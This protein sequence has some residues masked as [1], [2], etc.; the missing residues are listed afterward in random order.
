MS[1][2]ELPDLPPTI[3]LL[4]VVAWRYDCLERAGWPRELATALAERADVDLHLAV[5]L[6]RSGATIDQ[7]LEIVG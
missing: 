5:D 3:R 4:D 2:S 1:H 7:A 6:L